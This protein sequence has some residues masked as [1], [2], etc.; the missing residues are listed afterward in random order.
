MRGPFMRGYREFQSVMATALAGAPSLP[1]IFSGRQQ[2]RK[3]HLGAGAEVG[4]VFYT[5]DIPGEEEAVARQ[6]GVLH[7]VEAG[8]V[9]PYALAAEG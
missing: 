5:Y 7:R 8:R 3:G 2:N 4:K 6:G 1:A 9:E